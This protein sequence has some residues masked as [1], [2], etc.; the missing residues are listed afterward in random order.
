MDNFMDKLAQ[1]LNAQEVIKANSQ[2]EA[3]EMKRMR[4]Q[5]EAYNECLSEIREL[6]Q[7]NGQ[8]AARAQETVEKSHIQTEK[9]EDLTMRAAELVAQT[10]KLVDEGLGKIT[11]MPDEDKEARE[12]L[13]EDVRTALEENQKKLAELF[14]QSDEF[15]H[16]ENVKV[17]RNV[18][19]VIVDELKA[20]TEQLNTANAENIKK[21]AALKP[22]MITA[23]VLGGINAVMLAVQ[24]LVSFG[25]I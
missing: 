15:V 18:Q 7:K 24:L 22:L 2:A 10:Q 5:L 21:N 23:I 11:D 19:A 14:A 3:A 9:A 12:R 1:K 17:Y 20:Q 13:L 6:N 25:I 16:K 8:L 4:V